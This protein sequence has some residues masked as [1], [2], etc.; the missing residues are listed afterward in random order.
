METDSTWLALASLQDNYIWGNVVNGLAYLVD[1]GQARPGI[2]WLESRRLPLDAILVTHR[3]ADHVGGIGQLLEKWPDAQVIAPAEYEGREVTRTVA[4]G[5]RIELADKSL[6][7]SVLATC[8]H[9]RGHVSYLG[10]GFV[11]CGDALFAG[12]CGRLFEGDG[13][14]LLASME[15]F[16]A[17]P[18]DTLVCCGHE[19]TLANLRFARA[20]DPENDALRDFS[21]RAERLAAE[22][23]PT[24]PTTIGQE[25]ATNPFLR[26]DSEAVIESVRQHVGRAISEPA[27]I[28]FQ[29]RC[30]K[31]SF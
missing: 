12:G 1:P 4:A 28:L 14:D 31:D 21:E 26:H 24:V 22:G 29:L 20:V 25:L 16:R 19:Y 11:L 15:V 17:M 6:T 30:W 9:T 27:E 3:H 5:E 2:D 8:G 23:K 13:N 7:L 18:A 10:A